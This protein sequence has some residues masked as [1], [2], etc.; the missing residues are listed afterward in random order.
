[1]A[2]KTRIPIPQVNKVRAILQQEVNSKC[3]F[4]NNEDVAYFEIHHI[5]KNPSNNNSDNL[6]LLCSIC[7]KK[8]DN[9]EITFQETNDVKFK[10]KSNNSS[11]QFISV[12]ID[13]ENCGWE[14]I[15]DVP[16]A[17]KIDNTNKSA[18]PILNFN[19]INN[20]DKTILLT[21]VKLISKILPIGLSGPAIIDNFLKPSP[22][23][24]M[25]IS[26][27]GTIENLI[28]KDELIIL[29]K[30]PV[31]I[32]ILLYSQYEE[33]IFSPKGKY[34]LSFN[35]KFNNDFWKD[36]PNV[37]LNCKSENEKLQYIGYN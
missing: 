27:N 24:E 29:P 10:T 28:L 21:S 4:C 2:K 26:H 3:P 31:K 30:M 17:F 19:F 20:L 25:K 6:I 12:T 32:Q 7:H 23:F 9:N 13:S 35:F 22:F 37:V 33:H 5:D 14:P 8:A 16:N 11:V 1:M 15:V 36:I 34:V 18:F